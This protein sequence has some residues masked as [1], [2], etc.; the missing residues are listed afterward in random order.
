M[1]PET[2]R[3]AATDRLDVRSADGTPLALWVEG[4][5]PAV[6]LVH[7][8]L[9]DHT[10]FEALI[11]ELG[12]ALTTYSIDRRGFGASGD[13]A[14]YCIER[15]FEDVAAVVDAVAASS[16][17][18][19]ALFGHSFGANCAMGGAALT[20]NIRHLVLYEPSLGL[21][22]PAGSIDAIEEAVAAGDTDRAVV[23]VLSGILDMTD[24]EIAA[25]RAGPR[26]A[27][28][29]AAPATVPRECRVEER[30]TYRRGQFDSIAAP[31]VL[32][33]GSKSPAALQHAT[34]RAAAAIPA[35]RIHMLEGHG[36]LAHK[37]DPALIAATIRELIAS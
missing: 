27:V 17:G 15:E 32:L 9:S 18:P 5:G 6:V 1:N 30:W 14:G 13:A 31:T 29:V 21:A 37:T 20:P 8:S 22:Y 36:H 16:G 35:A 34:Q 33:A 12:A 3:P 4:D 23:A 11:H 26:W 7:G 24:D 25:L 2:A 10:T 28:L 19:V